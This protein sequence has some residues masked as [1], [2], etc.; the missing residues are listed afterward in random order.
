MRNHSSDVERVDG[1]Q[2][3][4]K[5]DSGIPTDFYFFSGK[6]GWD[7]GEIETKEVGKREEDILL[8]GK[9]GWDSGEIETASSPL[10]PHA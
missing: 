3:R 4:L 7:S 6:G 5:L 10:P 9:G 1:T 2:A 8:C